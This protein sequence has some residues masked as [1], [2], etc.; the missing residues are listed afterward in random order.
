[1]MLGATVTPAGGARTQHGRALA[2]IA[3]GSP[4][5]LVALSACLD[6]IAAQD[7]GGMILQ[8]G[9]MSNLKLSRKASMKT[10]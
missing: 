2:G 4:E 3:R 9:S 7:L 8:I 5:N 10:D 1:M 6:E